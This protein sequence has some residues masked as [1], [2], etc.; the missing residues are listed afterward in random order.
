[1]AKKLASSSW[2]AVEPKPYG[3]CGICPSAPCGR[4]A[5]ARA[6]QA[7]PQQ[8]SRMD[9]ADTPVGGDGPALDGVEVVDRAERAIRSADGDQ[10]RQRRLHI[11]CLVSA[12]AL[13]DGGPAVP[14]PREAEP[15]GGNR[16]RHRVEARRVPGLARVG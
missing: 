16:L 5:S 2:L 1:M 4:A 14:H 8:I 12:A 3:P 15:D 9:I 11:T 7:A 6:R 10:L 13:Q